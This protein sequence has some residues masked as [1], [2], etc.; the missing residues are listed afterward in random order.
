MLPRNTVHTT[1]DRDLLGQLAPASVD[2]IWSSP[3][4]NRRDPFRGGGRGPANKGQRYAGTDRAGEGGLLPEDAYQ[5]WQVGVLTRW[6]DLLTDDGVAFYA[7]LPRHKGGQLLHPVSWLA[8]APL[9]LLGEIVW[10]KGGTPN[11]STTRFYPCH[12]VI[13]VLG[14][15]RGVPL[16]NGCKRAPPCADGDCAAG[17]T[18][19]RLPDVWRV[20]PIAHSRRRAQHPA[21]A[22]PEIVRR[23]LAAVKP[24]PDGRRPLVLDCWAGVGTTGLVAQQLGMDYLLGERWPGYVQRARALLQAG[25]GWWVGDVSRETSHE[26]STTYQAAGGCATM[27][28]GE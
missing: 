16:V 22:H 20:P 7:H 15:R 19:C 27:A 3:P 8:R 21:P 24:L 17:L 9:T 11:T 5:A 12:E 10:D 1:L 26:K 2:I 6:Y 28:E 23:C 4:F 25:Q 13:Y 14:K 18:R